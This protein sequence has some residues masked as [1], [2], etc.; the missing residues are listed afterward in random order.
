MLIKGLNLNE[1]FMFK[2]F[3]VMLIFLQFHV[4]LVLNDISETKPAAAMKDKHKPFFFSC[5]PDA[6]V[7]LP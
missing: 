5:L 2:I 3:T 6:M 1:E 7:K 4:S